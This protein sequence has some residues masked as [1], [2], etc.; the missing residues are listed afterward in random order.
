PPGSPSHPPTFA[1]EAEWTGLDW[2]AP[3]RSEPSTTA[4][5]LIATPSGFVA[6]GQVQTAAG[7]SV[8]AA[9]TSP[10]LR[11]WT[12][13]LLDAPAIGDSSLESVRR[14]DAGLV[15]IGLSGVLQCVPPEGEGQV[16]DPLPIAIWT[17]SDGA[18]W[19]QERQPAPLVGVRV[20]SVASDGETV[21]LVGDAG[22]TRPG[23]WRSSDGA[24]WASAHP[25]PD[26]FADAHFDAVAAIPGR[27]WVVTGSTGGSE[28]V[29]CAGHNADATPAA[30]S[31][32]DG[33]TWEPALVVAAV[34]SRGDVVGPVFAGR[35]G[36]VAWSL[37]EQAN[38]FGWQSPDGRTWTALP[39]PVGN[40][41]TP[42]AGD[43]LRIIGTTFDGEDRVAEW[44][45]TDGL[46]WNR[47][48]ASGDVASRPT[49]SEG[50]TADAAFLLAGGVA[51]IGRDVDGAPLLW[52]STPAR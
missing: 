8:A 6:V 25:Q 32:A 26:T 13:T 1:E 35:D 3:L 18:S 4:S 16:C 11:S 52:W 51:W 31:S 27:G 28:P 37:G 46:R 33:I 22:W 45:S 17:S 20:A 12:R 24:I 36:M 10:D 23:I 15:A 2:S 40:A 48:A 49:W 41:I 50:R 5:D 29:C 34:A 44:I 43:G 19:T 9:W 21:F 38:D 42:R 30:W 7:G 39:K 47:L 14:T